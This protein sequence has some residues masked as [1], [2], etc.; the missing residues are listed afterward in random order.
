MEPT[1][2]WKKVRWRA[3]AALSAFSAATVGHEPV[4]RPRYEPVELGGADLV[5]DRRHQGVDVGGGFAVR[6]RGWRRRSGRP[7]TARRVPVCTRA[8]CRGRRYF[9]SRAWAILMRPAMVDRSITAANSAMQN[10]ATSGAPSPASGSGQSPPRS[11]QVAASSID[12][13]GGARPRSP[14]RAA[15]RPRPASLSP[16]WP[17]RT[18]APQCRSRGPPDRCHGSIQPAS[19]DSFRVEFPLS[20]GRILEILPAA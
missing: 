16:G 10:S 1:W 20:T 9:S 19:T 12:S 3:S 7:A 14:R 5:R 4:D 15:G 6:G 2:W 18:R 8:Q 17:G 13:V 11:A